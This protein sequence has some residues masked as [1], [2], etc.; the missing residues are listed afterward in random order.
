MLICLLYIEHLFLDKSVKLN[1]HRQAAKYI[2]TNI[3]YAYLYHICFFIIKID[4][5][6]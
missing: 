2:L 4:K 1:L 5:T 6:P 3:T